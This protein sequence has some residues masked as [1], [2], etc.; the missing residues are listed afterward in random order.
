MHGRQRLR[1]QALKQ[2]SEH[3]HSHKLQASKPA[4]A[5]KTQLSSAALR[6]SSTAGDD[7]ARQKGCCERHPK[8]PSCVPRFNALQQRVYP[9]RCSYAL[10][11]PFVIHHCVPTASKELG[12]HN[13]WSPEMPPGRVAPTDCQVQWDHAR[14]ERVFRGRSVYLIGDSMA[15]QQWRSLLCLAGQCWLTRTRLRDPQ[16]TDAPSDQ[17]SLSGAQPVSCRDQRVLPW[18]NRRL[19]KRPR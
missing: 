9:Q 16:S 2:H 8:M 13:C 19:T 18:P 12:R 7:C 3:K 15:D 4:L 1:P 6:N 14:F 11:C 10:D 17:L 5:M